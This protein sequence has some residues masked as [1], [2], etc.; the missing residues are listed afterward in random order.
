MTESAQYKE[1]T[2]LGDGE[3]ANE[4]LHSAWQQGGAGMGVVSR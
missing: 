3:H 4:F 1:Q 2:Y